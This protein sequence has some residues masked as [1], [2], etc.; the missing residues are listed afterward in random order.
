[1][2]F[3]WN[4]MLL[5]PLSVLYCQ[6]PALPA[7]TL[8][9]PA[10]EKMASQP[11]LPVGSRS[12]QCSSPLLLSHQHPSDWPL[13][14]FSCYSSS[15]LSLSVHFYLASSSSC[16]LLPHCC[17]EMTYFLSSR[18]LF[19]VIFSVVSQIPLTTFRFPWILCSQ[20]YSSPPHITSPFLPSYQYIPDSPLHSVAHDFPVYYIPECSAQGCEEE[21]DEVES[22]KTFV[23]GYKCHCKSKV[24]ETSLL[25]NDH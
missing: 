23:H 11:H 4:H 10:V 17:V 25:K 20:L 21:T 16:Q 5:I 12:D 18:V 1:M 2:L 13:Q 8:L 15:S 9:R 19:I 7:D 22:P 14:Y 24:W 3:Q 6:L